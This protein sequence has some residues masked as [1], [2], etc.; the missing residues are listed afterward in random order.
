MKRK[1][2]ILIAVLALSTLFFA[3]KLNL[4]GQDKGKEAGLALLRQA[5]GVEA[6][7]AKVKRGAHLDAKVI[8]GSTVERQDAVAG[9]YYHVAVFDP[10]ANYPYYTAEVNAVTGIAYR[11]QLDRKMIKLTKEQKKEA[12]ALGTLNSFAKTDFTQQEQAATEAAKGFVE[13][14]FAANDQIL[15]VLPRESAT[16][17]DIFPMVDIDSLIIMK[18]GTVY[19]VTVCWPSM[20]VIELQILGEEQ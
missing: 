15:R 11:A 19:Q 1:I 4:V 18:S 13:T 7:E 16:T 12:A 3:A 6:T 8:N 10:V 9:N 17:S 5:Y 14:H 20:H 2:A